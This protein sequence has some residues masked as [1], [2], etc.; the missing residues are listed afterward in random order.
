[1][2]VPVAGKVA[3]QLRTMAPDI[4]ALVAFQLWI[5]VRTVN[6]RTSSRVAGNIGKSLRRN[7]LREAGLDGRPPVSVEPVLWPELFEWLWP[8]EQFDGA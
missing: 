8:A 6:W 2:M 4:D 7:L 3:N 1:M 5:E